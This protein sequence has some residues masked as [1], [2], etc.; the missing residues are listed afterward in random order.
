[1]EVE[2]VGRKVVLLLVV[3]VWGVVVAVPAPR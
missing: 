3:V 1:V 2:G